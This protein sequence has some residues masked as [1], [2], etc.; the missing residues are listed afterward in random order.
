MKNNIRNSLVETTLEKNLKLNFLRFGKPL[1]PCFTSS[2]FLQGYIF[3][4]KFRK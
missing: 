1:L 4:G 2:Y 3:K